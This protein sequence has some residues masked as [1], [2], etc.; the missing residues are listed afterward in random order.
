MVARIV[1]DT[2]VFVS[3]LIRP[4]R[5]P[6]QVLRMCLEGLAMPLMG[7]ALFS[8]YEAVMARPEIVDRSPLG[9]VERGELLDAFMGACRWVTIH[10]LWRPNLPDE[11]DNHVIELAVAGGASWIVTGNRRDFEGSEMAFPEIGI[12]TPAGF[13]AQ[14]N[15]P[16]P[17]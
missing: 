2:N 7:N 15:M 6:R 12:V 5:A 16:W 14:E 1:V 9:P 3:A 17:R 11:A 13:V 8:E 4:D 10:Y